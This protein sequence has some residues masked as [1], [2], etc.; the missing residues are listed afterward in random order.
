MPK[1]RSI[2]TALAPTLTSKSSK[3]I[4]GNHRISA[5]LKKAD[6]VLKLKD[7]DA[8]TYSVYRDGEAIAN[9][10]VETT[11][12][13][14]NALKGAYTV[15]A[16]A[17]GIESAAS[18]AVIIDQNLSGVEG[19]E[20]MAIRYDAAAQRVVLAT[21]A[22]AVV[23]NAAGAMVVVADNASTIDMSALP[24]GVYVVKSSN[25]TLRVVK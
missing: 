18:N 1:V 6:S 4:N 23:Y 25:A 12:T 10:I 3:K 20:T 22:D 24:A 7:A 11:Y 2:V 17:N 5:V 13:V 15:T 14:A 8:T 16:V 19:V 9:G 21:A